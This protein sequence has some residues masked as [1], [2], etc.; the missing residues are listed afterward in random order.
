MSKTGDRIAR[1]VK[2][3][4]ISLTKYAK[5]IG[6]SQQTLSNWKNGNTINIQNED[7]AKI[8]QAR[9]IPL[10]ELIALRDEDL[11]KAGKRAKGNIPDSARETVAKINGP[12]LGGKIMDLPIRG[13]SAGG[14]MERVVFSSNDIYDWA[15]RPGSLVGIEEAYGVEMREMSMADRYLPNKDILHV[16]PRMPYYV[17]DDVIVHVLD[18]HSNETLGFVKQFKGWDGDRAIFRQINPPKTIRFNRDDI[19]AIHPIVGTG[20]K[21]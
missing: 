18:R 1:D 21:R 17:D 4:G 3:H 16:N 8:S 20:R 7:L 14:N 2:E 5:A 15:D 6:V 13:I 9:G 10:A 12:L 11:A 19:V